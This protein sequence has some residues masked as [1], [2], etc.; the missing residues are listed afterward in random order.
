MHHSFHSIWINECN[1]ICNCEKRD[2]TSLNYT[3][4]YEFNFK[5]IKVYE[6]VSK[7]TTNNQMMKTSLV[8]NYDPRS[9]L[10]EGDC[11]IG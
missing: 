4:W 5:F 2:R 9:G 3:V 7:I 11:K 1:N 10:E 8:G 6:N